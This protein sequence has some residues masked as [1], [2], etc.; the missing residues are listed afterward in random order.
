MCLTYDHY[1]LNYRNNKDVSEFFE[2]VKLLEEQIDATN[3]E[4]TPN[5]QTLLC[6]TMVFQNKSHYQ[7]LVQIQGITKDITVEK[8][9]EMLLEVEQRLKADSGASALMMRTNG[10]QGK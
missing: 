8:V 6:W 4:I 5:K 2:H 10:H 7:L 3:I 1:M 9:Q